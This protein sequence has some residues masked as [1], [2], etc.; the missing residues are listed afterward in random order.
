MQ[1][2]TTAL[3]DHCERVRSNPSLNI[4]RHLVHP[5]THELG[6]FDVWC[7]A[8]CL[9]CGTRWRRWANAYEIVAE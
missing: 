3:C 1:S 5:R 9:A 7:I 6:L 2:S 4:P 8:M